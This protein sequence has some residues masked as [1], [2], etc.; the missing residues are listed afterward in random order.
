VLILLL[1]YA[2][3]FFPLD[4]FIVSRYRDLS[5]IFSLFLDR[6]SS[7]PLC[8]FFHCPIPTCSVLY[9]FKTKSKLFT[10][11]K[12]NRKKAGVTDQINN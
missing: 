4:L 5:L 8:C 12:I 1:D 11:W 2:D 3:I 9:V 6:P 7:F 10:K